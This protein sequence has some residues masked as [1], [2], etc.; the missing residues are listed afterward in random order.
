[1]VLEPNQDPED[2]LMATPSSTINGGKFV[3]KVQR[4]QSSLLALGTPLT[5]LSF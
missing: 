3:A 4:D 5:N 1:M 2:S